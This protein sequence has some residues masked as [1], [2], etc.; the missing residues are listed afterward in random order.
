[1][2]EV[3]GMDSQTENALRLFFMYEVGREVQRQKAKHGEQPNLPELEAAVILAEEHGEV[4]K[5]VNELYFRGH[6]RTAM[7]EEL[8]QEAACAFRMWARSRPRQDAR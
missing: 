5:A 1:M 8:V 2:D 6:Q 4:M 7:E 3:P